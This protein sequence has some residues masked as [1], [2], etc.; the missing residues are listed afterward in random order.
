MKKIAFY[1]KNLEIGGIEKALVNLLNQLVNNYEIYLF[2]EEKSGV[3]LNHLDKRIIVQEYKLCS[4]NNTLIRK[5]I[6]FTK[7]CFFYL[8]FHNKFYFS[9]SYATYSVIC[10]KL[11]LISSKNNSL[12]IH[13]NYADVYKNDSDSLL[14]FF[15]LIFINLKSYFLFLLNQKMSY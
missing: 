9:C 7:R 14:D 10:S 5:I 11:A 2:L 13:S 3:L 15:S 12:Y 8:K 1:S 6:N 4:F